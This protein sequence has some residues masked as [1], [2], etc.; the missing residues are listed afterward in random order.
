MAESLAIGPLLSLAWYLANWAKDRWTAR[1]DN[2]EHSWES[3]QLI[4]SVGRLEAMARAKSQEISYLDRQHGI[5]GS[6]LRIEI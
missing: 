3:Q 4:D 5:N 6:T 2:R 1:R